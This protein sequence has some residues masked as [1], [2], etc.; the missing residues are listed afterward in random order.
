[1]KYIIITI[2]S[3]SILLTACKKEEPII[4][5]ID[6]NKSK[7]SDDNTIKQQD[8][9]KASSTIENENQDIEDK[10]IDIKIE[11]SKEITPNEYKTKINISDW[12]T[13]KNK[14]LGYSVKYPKEW[15]VFVD[16]DS[17]HIWRDYKRWDENDNLISVVDIRNVKLDEN[18]GCTLGG[19]F[20]PDPGFSFRIIVY[21]KKENSLDSVARECLH[22]SEINK[23]DMRSVNNGNIEMLIIDNPNTSC[24]S[25]PE[26]A[27]IKNDKLYK[28]EV[29]WYGGSPVPGNIGYKKLFYI[30]LEN[31]KI[32]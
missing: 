15:N 30:I 22:Y 18:I 28:F 20:E 11:E 32:E 8:T 25:Y 24:G 10:I 21:D 7:I 1:M 17:K 6:D 5:N 27:I 31:I 13:Y 26:M 2:L 9:V 23:C 19:P 12:K 29:V 14:E 3:L 16:E 4:N